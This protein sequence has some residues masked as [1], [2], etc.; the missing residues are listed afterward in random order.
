MAEPI[1]ECRI[2]NLLDG[3]QSGDGIWRHA[4]FTFRCNTAS[5]V[6]GSLDD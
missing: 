1:A 3:K 4:H 2:G 6:R 5:I